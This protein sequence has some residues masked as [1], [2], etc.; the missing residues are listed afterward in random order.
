MLKA[1]GRR[2]NIRLTALIRKVL[3]PGIRRRRRT[4]ISG[5]NIAADKISIKK[6]IIINSTF[7]N[8]FFCNSEIRIEK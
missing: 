5:E 2:E 7:D 6:S 8:L 1:K 4:P 3:F